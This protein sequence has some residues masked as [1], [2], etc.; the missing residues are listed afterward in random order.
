[1]QH[2]FFLFINDFQQWFLMY[3]IYIHV[4]M[5]ITYLYFWFLNVFDI[6]Y[7]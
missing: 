1:M 7:C 6:K 5:C 3:N 2:I 4:N